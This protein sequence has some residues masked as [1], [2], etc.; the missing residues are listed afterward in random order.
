M[1]SAI[2]AG[3]DGT[4]NGV[5]AK[6][7]DHLPIY[8]Y[9]RDQ[10]HRVV[11]ANQY[12]RETFGEPE[13]EFCYRLV[14][15]R[16]EPCRGCRAICL[17]DCDSNPDRPGC[18]ISVDDREYEVHGYQLVD[19]DGKQAVLKVGLD[20]TRRRQAENE[21]VS[22][23]S[24]LEV[25]ERVLTRSPAVAFVWSM[26]DGW[27]ISYVS[28]NVEQFGYH[29]EAFSSGRL[30]M[31]D[32][33]HPDDLDRVRA[34]V[35]R[36][37][38]E[39]L[40]EYSQEYRILT[41]SG[42]VRW[43]DD[44]TWVNLVDGEAVDHQGIILD[45][46]LRKE[47]QDALAESEEK[48]RQLFNSSNDAVMVYLVES[49]TRPGRFIEVND[50]ACKRLGYT[51][52]E[53]LRMTPDQ[54]QGEESAEHFG[55]TLREI[56]RR[57]NLLIEETH[58]TRDGAP[59]SVEAN[60]HLVELR[61]RRVVMSVARDVTWRKASQ[62]ALL[63]S[64]ARFRQLTENIQEVFWLSDPMLTKFHYLSPAVL[65]ITGRHREEFIS[66]PDLWRA[67]IHPDELE[68]AE[69]TLKESEPGQWRMEGR[70]IRLDGQVRWVS[71]RSFPI[72]NR[73]GEVYRIAG[74]VEDVT[75]RHNHER[76]LRKAIKQAEA[77]DRAKTRFLAT[78]SHELRTPLG[79]VVGMA[80][81]LNH[82]DLDEDQSEY[83]EA[84]GEAAGLLTERIGDILLVARLE[85]GQLALAD[86]PLEISELVVRTVNR[87][88]AEAQAKG[89]TI[90]G[91]V[92]EEG[93]RVVLGDGRTISLI[94]DKLVQNAVKFTET[95]GVGLAI[96]TIQD[97]KG[98]LTLK[99]MVSDS[100][101][102]IPEEKLAH[103]L[104]PFVQADDELSRSH[105]GTGLGLSIVK[106]LVVLHRGRLTLDSEPGQGTTVEVLIPVREVSGE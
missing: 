93:A 52:T 37:H 23:R 61:G 44:R 30:V 49:A 9:I 26:A 1:G 36:N 24:D 88:K 7:L 71:I 99:I 11:Y 45:I 86:D 31:A 17:E 57:G 16:E 58:L 83:L 4:D 72:H 75:D 19:S 28:P 29:P 2:L 102:G 101:I 8:V 38:R 14:Q 13:G 100:G 94:L 27:P 53:L 84:I 18:L 5:L 87:F 10:D 81:L 65:K 95:G 46:T 97:E 106:K 90:E 96:G 104:E 91:E 33:V 85:E 40:V 67:M 51:R 89:L 34:E 68:F 32:L 74:L 78:V 39:G 69:R 70:L 12:F 35:E 82:T 25:L 6:V 43:V 15:G 42:Q 98:S 60:H 21:L 76:E 47:A 92:P 41:A 56:T 79:Q 103:I 73:Q 105:G 66:R 64:E 59:I 77:A 55:D 22:A 50:I 54:I 80:D 3:F 48:F 62:A 20:I 63:E